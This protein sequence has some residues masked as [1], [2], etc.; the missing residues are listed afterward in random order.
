[1]NVIKVENKKWCIK[2]DF[3]YVVFLLV[4]GVEVVNLVNN[5]IMDYF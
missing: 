3:V 4:S 2:S 1:M 5:Y